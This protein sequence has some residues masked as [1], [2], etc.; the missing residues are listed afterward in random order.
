MEGRLDGGVEQ[1]GD[2]ADS[3]RPGTEEGTSLYVETGE[4]AGGRGWEGPTLK[5]LVFHF[6]FILYCPYT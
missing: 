2:G 6:P 4:G 1:A 3:S 5:S